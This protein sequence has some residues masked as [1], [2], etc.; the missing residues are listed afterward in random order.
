MMPKNK[1]RPRDRTPTLLYNTLPTLQHTLTRVS[2]KECLLVQT[3][4]LASAI[5]SA[6]LGTERE[7][8]GCWEMAHMC[9]ETTLARAQ[10]DQQPT[11]DTPL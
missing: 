7:F 9:A 6:S 3:T 2:T 4:T 10:H 5:T 11:N 1:M 8:F